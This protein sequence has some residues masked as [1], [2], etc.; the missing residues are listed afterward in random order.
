[1][2]VPSSEIMARPQSD[3]LAPARS[4]STSTFAV[5]PSCMTRPSRIRSQDR[6]ATGLQRKNTPARR[7][8]FTVPNL[9]SIVM[10]RRPLAIPGA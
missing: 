3:F 9:S 6:V 10:N 1:M 4:R 2:V 7:I 8:V 5:P